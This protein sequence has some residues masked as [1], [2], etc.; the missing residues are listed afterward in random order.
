MRELTAEVPAR[1]VSEQDPWVDREDFLQEVMV[2]AF[3]R[4]KSQRD[5]INAMPVYPTEGILWDEN[6]IP[7]VHYTGTELLPGSVP[8][9]EARLIGQPSGASR[10]EGWL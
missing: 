2:A 7:N 8:S 5:T 1:L 3:E 4:R 6:Q 9:C 10:Y